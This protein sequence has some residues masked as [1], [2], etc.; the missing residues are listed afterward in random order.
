MI[1]L[2]E[3]DNHDEV[4]EPL[5]EALEKVNLGEHIVLKEC[6]QDCVD[7]EMSNNEN[8]PK[9][10]SSSNASDYVGSTIKQTLKNHVRSLIEGVRHNIT[11]Y[12]YQTGNSIGNMKFAFKFQDKKDEDNTLVV[13]DACEENIP[14]FTTH[15]CKR[16]VKSVMATLSKSKIMAT[17]TKA[18]FLI[19]VFTDQSNVNH[20]MS[21]K[22]MKIFAEDLSVLQ[23]LENDDLLVDSL[24]DYK[25]FYGNYSTFD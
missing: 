24:L 14:K 13:I 20:A 19:N 3:K 10:K 1:Y 9:M 18:L 5:C 21:S 15:Y 25:S 17:N 7:S 8:M 23:V 11:H 2:H 6:E 22:E 4:L 12:N 16:Q